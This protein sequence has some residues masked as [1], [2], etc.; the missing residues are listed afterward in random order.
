MRIAVEKCFMKEDHHHL[1]KGKDV[2]MVEVN[3]L[4]RTNTFNSDH[5]WK[6]FMEEVERSGGRRGSSASTNFRGFRRSVYT[7]KSQIMPYVNNKTCFK[8][9]KTRSPI[10]SLWHPNS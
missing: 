7:E 1:T 4:F 3:R 2:G 8:S 6:S 10:I 9:L 5:C